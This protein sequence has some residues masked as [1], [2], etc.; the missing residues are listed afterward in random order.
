MVWNVG[1]HGH[2][3]RDVRSV[4]CAVITISDTRSEAEDQSGRRIRELL[5]S[6]GHAAESYRIV[7]DEPDQIV[8]VLEG[9]PADVRAVICNGGTG[10]AR[11]DTTYEAISGLLEK[12]IP[13]FGEL[14][15]SLS[16]EEIGAAA[17]LSRAAAGI[18]GNRVVFALPGSTAAV[19]LA[20]TR[21]ILPQLGHIAGLL[22][23]D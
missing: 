14:F 15:R 23:G 18:V 2:H 21:L 7:R 16:Y 13:G 5:R 19:E 6:R 11:R 1:G 3:K 8:G 10:L 20:M 22:A 17:M 9:L 4:E 12:E